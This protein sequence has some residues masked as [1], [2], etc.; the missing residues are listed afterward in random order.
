MDTPTQKESL[1]ILK[2]RVVLKTKIFKGKYEPKL[3]FLKGGGF[4][5]PPPCTGWGGGGMD[6]VWNITMWF[7]LS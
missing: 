6:V 1:E 2:G 4:H 3:E 7:K 5:T